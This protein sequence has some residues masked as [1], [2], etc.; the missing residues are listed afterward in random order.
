[1]TAG[2]NEAFWRFHDRA[3]ADQS[4]LTDESFAS[5]ALDSGVDMVK[6]R[7]AVLSRES[8]ARVDTS[9]VIAKEAGVRGTPAFFVNGILLS[10]AQ[11]LDKF[12]EVIEA[13]KIAARDAVAAGTRPE[14]VY[15]KLSRQNKA[16]APPPKDESAAKDETT[17]WRVPVGTSPSRGPLN[18]PVTI[19]EFGDLQCPF[20]RRAAATLIEVRARYGAKVRIVWKNN[21]LGFHTRAEPAAEVAMEAFH[22]QGDAVFWQMHDLSYENQAHLDDADLLGYARRLRV[23]GAPAALADKKHATQIKADQALAKSLDA[24]GTPTF[25]INGRRLSG[26]QPLAKFAT[27][28][29]EELRHAEALVARGVAPGAVYAEIQKTA[30]A[31]K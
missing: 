12:V 1:M 8:E 25:F 2:G 22:A 29:D 20:C 28:I 15:A 4:A 19:V 18:A 24:T 31:G 26:A 16:K 7:A 13:Q 30:T 14:D 9:I 23:N 21:P 17:V 3:F 27:I 5:W 11:P 6:W 10:G